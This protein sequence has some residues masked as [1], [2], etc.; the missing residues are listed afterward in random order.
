MQFNSL[1]SIPLLPHKLLVLRCHT[2]SILQ[3]R[4]ER[5]RIATEAIHTVEL[6]QLGELGKQIPEADGEKSLAYRYPFQV[7]MNE[8][9][10]FTAYYS[11]SKCNSVDFVRSTA[12]I[13]QGYFWPRLV[14]PRMLENDLRN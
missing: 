3:K 14:V 7:F 5:G 10:S 8:S 13:Q 9:S 12:H 4:K 1:N 11:S 6:A 2:L